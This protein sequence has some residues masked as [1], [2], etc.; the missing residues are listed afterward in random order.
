MP[1][2]PQNNTPVI[3]EAESGALSIQVDGK[4]ETVWVTQQQI[5]DLFERE[6]SV[7]TKHLKSIYEEGELDAES[8]VQKMHIAGSTKPVSVYNLDVV[9]A[10]GYR[11]SSKK[12]TAFRQWATKALKGVLTDGYVVD[13]ERLGRDPDAVERLAE[14]VRKHRNGEQNLYQTVRDVF[15]ASAADYDDQ[16]EEELRHFFALAQD[17]FHYAVT[18]RT[19]AQI[20][21]DRVS[22]RKKNCGLTAFS[23]MYPTVKEAQIAKNYLSTEELQGLEN[24]CEQFLL[25]AKSAAFRGKKM[26]LEELT[27]KLN[28]LLMANEYPI[29]YQHPNVPLRGRAN[30]K[31]AS[32][33]KRY[34]A[35]IGGKTNKPLPNRTVADDEEED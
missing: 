19:S 3:Y 34:K 18:E 31:A 7:I 13:E 17:K 8:T 20:I 9:L 2:K 5:A 15:K 32:E 6:R 14:I 30:D 4:N 29:L 25:F 35:A 23:G 28:I 1:G 27:T 26:N 10:I 21:L 33:V 22:S 24:V 16:A 11:V 12:A